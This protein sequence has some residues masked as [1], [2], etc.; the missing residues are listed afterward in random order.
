MT[1][2]VKELFERI[3]S[4]SEKDRIALEKLLAERLEAEWQAEAKKARRL[5]KK[6]GLTMD[7]IDKAIERRRYGK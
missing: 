1:A 4:L 3:E 5:M 7:D 2:V 6:R